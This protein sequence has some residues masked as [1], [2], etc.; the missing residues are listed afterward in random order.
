VLTLLLGIRPSP[1]L[2][3]AVRLRAATGNPIAPVTGAVFDADSGT[4]VPGRSAFG[5]ARLPPF[6]QLDFEINN[7]WVSELFR[8]QLYLDFENCLNRL[9]PEAVLHDYRYA[10]QA[11]IHGLPSTAI[12]G[13]KVS[14]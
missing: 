4:Y 5:T 7:V 9:N 14:F 8:L 6:W 13:A 1:Y 10:G 3:F 12:V 2:E 11:Y